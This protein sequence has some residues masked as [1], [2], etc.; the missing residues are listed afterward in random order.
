VEWVEEL[1]SAKTAK[2]AVPP[3]LSPISYSAASSILQPR[4][5]LNDDVGSLRLRVMAGHPH[6]RKVSHH[7]TPPVPS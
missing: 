7:V 2:H 4:Q 1:L 5:C 6:L 3:A